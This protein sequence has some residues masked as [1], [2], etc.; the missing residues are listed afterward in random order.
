MVLQIQQIPDAQEPALMEVQSWLRVVQ[1]SVSITP[2]LLLLDLVV[3]I[4]QVENPL[5]LKVANY[6]KL[7][8]ARIILFPPQLDVL[9]KLKQ[10]SAMMVVSLI[11][12]ES[13]LKNKSLMHLKKVLNNVQVMLSLIKMENVL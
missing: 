11:L 8:N 10:N 12:K 9:K 2:K 7:N 1:K 4:A 3:V 6:P 13:V 5:L